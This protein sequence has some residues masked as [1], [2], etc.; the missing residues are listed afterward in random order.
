MKDERKPEQLDLFGGADLDNPPAPA[1]EVL[2]GVYY[3]RE[4]G[5]FVSFVLGRRHYEWPAKGCTFDKEWRERT[6]RE[7]AI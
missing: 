7:R 1:G 3:E 5:L 2:N 6:M 4:T